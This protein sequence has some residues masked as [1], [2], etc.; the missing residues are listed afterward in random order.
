MVASEQSWTVK[1]ALDWTVS[2][3]ERNGVEHPRRS[4]QWLLSAATGLSRVELYVHHDRPLTQQE[5][6]VLRDGVKRRAAGEPLQYVTGEMPFRH[7]VVKV[8]PG[9]FIPRPETETLVEEGLEFLRAHG[10]DEPLVV[11]LCTGSGCVACSVAHEYSSARV[12]AVDV[13]DLA[14]GT[15]RENAERIAVGERVSV[16]EGDLTSPLPGALRGRVDVVLANPPY[17]PSSDMDELPEEVAGFEPHRALDGG[18]DGLDIARRIMREAAIL[19]RPGGL[20]AMELDERRVEDA[21]KVM[22]QWYEQC[23]T[24]RDLAG[25]LRVATGRLRESPD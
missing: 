23:R 13:S 4:A 3:L 16:W 24:V 20:L 7:I 8:V 25:R 18:A 22:E 21:A 12:H 19:L 10:G 2:Y 9:V 1:S 17:I 15:A 14:V 11:D 6:D 5:R